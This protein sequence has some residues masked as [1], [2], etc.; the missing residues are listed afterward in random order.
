MPGCKYALLTQPRTDLFDDSGARFRTAF[1]QKGS[2]AALRITYSILS[3]LRRKY[4]SEKFQIYSSGYALTL[5]AIRESFWGQT[6][7]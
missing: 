5:R 2:E 1:C 7:S 3:L 6:D 4:V